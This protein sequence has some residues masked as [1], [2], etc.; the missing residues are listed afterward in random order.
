[1][2]IQKSEAILLLK[3][4]VRETSSIV[5]F[6]TS[7]FGKIKGLIKGA[8]GPQSKFGI[9]LQEFAKFDI[10][11]YQKLKAETFMVT[12]CDLIE[13]YTEIS[14][15]L[16]RRLKAYYVLEL[17]DKFTPFEDKS[18]DIYNLLNWI[19]SAI[20]KKRFID[21]AI[22]YFQLKLLEY[23]GYLPELKECANCSSKLIKDNY[24]SVRVAGLLCG[25]CRDVDIQAIP[26]S[27]GAISSI[28]MLRKQSID[29]LGKLNIT[30]SISKELSRMLE[31]FIAYHL[32]EHLKTHDFINKVSI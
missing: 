6:Y 9:Y 31:R 16:D 7:E 10:V 15:D 25:N 3:K 17:V 19:L 1:M 14:E 20:R 30:A 2:S 32:G 18:V 8:R 28:N 23:V 29:Q 5:I 13:P 27:R 24:F 21:R 11:Y 26:L 22:I 4:E 12:Q